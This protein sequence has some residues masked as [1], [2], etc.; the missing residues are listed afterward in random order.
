MISAKL[1]VG[2]YDRHNLDIIT[3]D[4]ANF[5]TIFLLNKQPTVFLCAKH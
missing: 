4:V 3:G 5:A 2:R 1:K